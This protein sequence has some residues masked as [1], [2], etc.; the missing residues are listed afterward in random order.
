MAITTITVPIELRDKLEGM[1]V[2]RKQPLY[3]V[4]EMLVK[5]KDGVDYEKRI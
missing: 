2:H 4:I 1:K 5:L 3:E